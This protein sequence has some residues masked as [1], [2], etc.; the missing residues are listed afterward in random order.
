[1]KSLKRFGFALWMI[2]AMMTLLQG[3]A[4]AQPLDPVVPDG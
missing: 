1:M 2:A 4:G 3:M